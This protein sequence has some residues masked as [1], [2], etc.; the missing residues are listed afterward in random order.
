MVRERR[1]SAH[2]MSVADEQADTF[3]TELDR[4]E[5]VLASKE[6]ELQRLRTDL[7]LKTL[8]VDELQATLDAQAREM[9]AFDTRLRQMETRVGKTLP[10]EIVTSAMSKPPHQDSTKASGAV[11][12]L[13][14]IRKG[15]RE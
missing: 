1:L 8:Y 5:R 12:L 13:I 14:R 4:L 6:A 2:Q 7:A 9:E 10:P 11:P 3:G 15:T